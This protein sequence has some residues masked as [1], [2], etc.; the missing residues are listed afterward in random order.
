M[1]SLTTGDKFS[2]TIKE[3]AVCHHAAYGPTFPGGSD[4]L[5]VNKANENFSCG[6]INCTYKNKS[7]KFKDRES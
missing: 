6:R 5:I 2:L 3:N 4:F 1:F 7:Y